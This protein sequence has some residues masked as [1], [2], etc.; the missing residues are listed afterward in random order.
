MVYRITRPILYMENL[1]GLFNNVD[2]EWIE[3]EVWKFNR[4]YIGIYRNK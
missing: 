3:I 4:I 1:L 2:K